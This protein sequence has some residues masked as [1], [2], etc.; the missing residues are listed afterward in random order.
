MSLKEEY[1]FW[2]L[3]EYFISKLNYRMIQLS[4]NQHE[5]WLEKVENKKAPIVR[6]LVHELD[7][8]N[9]MQRDIEFTAQNGE[10]IRRQLRRSQLNVLNVYISPYPP[11]DDYHYRLKEPF[12][13]HDGKKTEVLT[14][15]MAH[16]EFE[17]G[18]SQ[19]TNL[20][21]TDA[22]FTI[23]ETYSE[24]EVNFVKKESLNHAV[25]KAR[26]ESDVFGNG[27]P[28]F[29]YTFLL[30]QIAVFFWLELHGGS[31]NTSTLI[32]YGAKFNPLIY[33]GEWWR[34]IT[35]VFLHIGFMHLAMNSLALYYLGITVE[36]IFGNIRF[37]IIYLFAGVTGFIASFL[38]SPTLS[39]GASGAIF[40]CFG[41]LLYFGVA[42]PKLFYRTMG[43]NLFVVLAINLVFG[44]TASGIDNAGHLGGL[45]GGFLGAGIVSFPKKKKP[46]L[47]IIFL[48]IAAVAVWG[49]LS[50]GFSET[51]RAKDVGSNLIL[52]QDYIQQQ[53]YGEAYKILKDT[54]K[55]SE[56]PTAQLYFLLSFT[57]IKKGMLPDAEDHL[58]QAIKLNPKF[59]EA[60]YNLALIYLEEND[61]V[62]AK[63]FAER[64][65]QIKPEQKEYS[66]LVNEINAHIQSSGGGV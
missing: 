66:N 3:A 30:I 31:T 10:K 55:N 19:L 50:Y 2:R 15:I 37:V 51:V 34:F 43:I 22:F 7:W 27:R 38:F 41:A 58:Q 26:K 40:G 39:A 20:F 13:Y 47:Q 23:N 64:A 46:L 11:V 59:H 4:E 18:F 33:K 6:L 60:Y 61:L 65:A 24:T 57:E 12:V 28:I 17:R 49:S 5:L 52:A 53:Q 56:K 14:V 54:Q 8:S 63:K 44:F 32:K 62:Q 35:P 25:K 48:L 9:K 1:I 42:Y 36:R 29:T 16:G 21:D 45:V